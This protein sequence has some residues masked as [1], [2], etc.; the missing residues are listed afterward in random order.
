M[1][2]Y[3]NFIDTDH[4]SNCSNTYRYICGNIWRSRIPGSVWGY[5]CGYRSNRWGRKTHYEKEKI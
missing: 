2:F 5:N 1:M 4:S 3:D